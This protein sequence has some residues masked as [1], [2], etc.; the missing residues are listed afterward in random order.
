RHVISKEQVGTGLQIKTGDIDGNGL[1]DI[2]V[3]GKSGTYI[4]FNKGLKK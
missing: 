2:A 4:L 1:N 3:A